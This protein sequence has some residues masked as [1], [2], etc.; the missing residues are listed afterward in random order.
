MYTY[1]SIYIY[2][3]IRVYSRKAYSYSSIFDVDT[4]KIPGSQRALRGLKGLGIIKGP[5]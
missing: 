1:A 2:T 3:Y 4:M 5:Y